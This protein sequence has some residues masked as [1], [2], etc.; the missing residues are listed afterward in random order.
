MKNRKLLPLIGSVCLILVIAALPFITSCAAAPEKVIDL[1]LSHWIPGETHFT[2]SIF[3]PVVDYIN[4]HG[5]GRVTSTHY[6]GGALGGAGEQWEMVLEGIADIAYL[7]PTFEPGVFPL[8]ELM[9]MGITFPDNKIA[10]A[11]SLATYERILY[12]EYTKVKAFG[13]YRTGDTYIN[14][15]DK[16][17]TKLEDMKGLRLR[18]TGGLTTVALEALGSIPVAMP[19]PDMYLSMKTG[20]VDGAGNVPSFMITYKMHEVTKYTVMFG[21]GTGTCVFIMNLDT[22]NKLPKDLQQVVQE[23]CDLGTRLNVE[24]PD[25][26]QVDA[27]ALMEQTGEYY[28]LS[29]AEME[30]W[31]D[32]IRPEYHKWVADMDAKGLEGTKT[33]DIFREE[34]EKRGFDFPY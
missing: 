30:R 15:V 33:L 28:P 22:W 7:V 34:C 26:I 10:G 9:G 1:K 4:E 19:P 25:T 6:P 21:I 18:S 11:A 5:G 12:K 8:S 14:F 32:A 3:N 17:V 16:K 23:A 29:P 2:K 31:Y 20:V 24:Y 27:R 13:V